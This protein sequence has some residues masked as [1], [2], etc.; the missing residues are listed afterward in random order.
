VVLR[1][2]CNPT[3]RWYTRTMLDGMSKEG[4]CA[5]TRYEDKS[6]RSAP[7]L[8]VPAAMAG[9]WRGSR[10]LPTLIRFFSQQICD[11]GNRSTRHI[12]IYSGQENVSDEANGSFST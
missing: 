9:C 3:I 10:L 4:Q 2:T 11:S 5:V 12:L 6:P 1:A 8:Q 7:M